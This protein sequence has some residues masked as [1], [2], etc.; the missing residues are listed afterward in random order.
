MGCGS[1]RGWEVRASRLPKPWAVYTM[2]TPGVAGCGSGH[3]SHHTESSCPPQTGAPAAPPPSLGV[4]GASWVPG[5]GGQPSELEGS[6][7]PR[8][9]GSAVAHAH[10]RRLPRA[11][12]ALW[13]PGV[14]GNQQGCLRARDR[15][16][17]CCRRRGLEPVGHDEQSGIGQGTAASVQGKVEAIPIYGPLCAAGSAVPLTLCREVK[18]RRACGEPSLHLLCWKIFRQKRRLNP[19]RRIMKAASVHICVYDLGGWSRAHAIIHGAAGPQRLR[20]ATGFQE[21]GTL[22]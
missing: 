6:P 20:R 17:G 7:G 9:A 21:T 2:V 4:P 15:W 10:L 5:L 3:M 13:G 12:R 11:A 16:R 8:C 14:Q 19:T 1:C 18:P 22:E